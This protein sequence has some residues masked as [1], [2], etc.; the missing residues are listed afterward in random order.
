[1]LAGTVRVLAGLAFAINFSSRVAHRRRT[2]ESVDRASR[3]GKL[4]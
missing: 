1:M 4:F 2:V 3:S